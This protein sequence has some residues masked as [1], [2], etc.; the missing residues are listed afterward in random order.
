MPTRSHHQLLMGGYPDFSSN[1]KGANITIS[2]AHNKLATMG[3]PVWNSSR[4]ATARVS[5]KYY[6]E[7]EFTHGFG[8]GLIVAL[9]GPGTTLTDFIGA[10]SLGSAFAVYNN[11]TFGSYGL[12]S[13]GGATFTNTPVTGNKVMFAI[14][15]G[16]GKGW[17]KLSTD[18]GWAGAGADPATGANPMFTW[19]QTAV[20]FPGAS[21][22][23]STNSVT[24]NTGQ[25]AFTNTPPSGFNPWGQQLFALIDPLFSLVTNLL[26]FD[27][28]NGGTTF[29]DQLGVT[30]TA[31]GATTS[32]TQKK[33]GST[34][35]SFSGVQDSTQQYLTS[36][37]NINL[38]AGDFCVEGW[39][40]L[41]AFATGGGASVIFDT[42][43]VGTSGAYLIIAI[44]TSGGFRIT[45]NSVNIL[46]QTTG[47]LLALNTWT[48]FAITRNGGQFY[49]FMGGVAVGTGISDSTSY[50]A[51]RAIIG[52]S[53][54]A[55]SGA[56][57]RPWNGYI[58]EFRVTIGSGGSYRYAQ[59]SGT[60]INF[61]PYNSAFQNK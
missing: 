28:V 59:K 24:L 49:C 7:M 36:A 10:S 45:S 32:T 35:G 38:G 1:D 42:R 33:F 46:D 56:G 41:T 16:A 13:Y 6:F 18:S 26:H 51:N 60:G 8:G 48:H 54:F 61:I 55:L 15:L 2:G 47:T 19:G 20:W 40:Y 11:N 29:T 30:W 34:S 9:T 14:D 22:N 31:T 43:P 23:S 25:Q 57:T 37:S 3:A 17:C 4:G 52:G 21:I 44:N 12:I 53:G 27:G 58:D 50:T 5:G 39:L